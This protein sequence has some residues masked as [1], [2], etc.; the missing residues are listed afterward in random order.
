MYDSDGDTVAYDVP[1]STQSND[2][3]PDS[4]FK[5]DAGFRP[6]GRIV[7]VAELLVFV[8]LAYTDFV[9]W[10]HRRVKP[11]VRLGLYFFTGKYGLITAFNA[12][13]LASDSKISFPRLVTLVVGVMGM[14]AT[15]FFALV[16][17][18]DGSPDL[19]H[20]ALVS[21][22]CYNLTVRGWICLLVFT[23]IH[24][25]ESNHVPAPCYRIA[26]ASDACYLQDA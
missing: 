19:A 6:L 10:H 1:P 4:P 23:E 3:D 24:L 14:C 8:G 5:V 26:F 11:S 2:S 7:H 21:V 15:F 18:A 22:I 12:Y 16:A 9:I 25:P 13:T 20:Y 17:Y